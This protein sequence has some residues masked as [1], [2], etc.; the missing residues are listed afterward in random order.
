MTNATD[1]ALIEGHQKARKHERI[2]RIV[3]PIVALTVIGVFLFVIA[4]RVEQIDDKKL[5]AHLEKGSLRLTPTVEREL[6]S[7]GD[8]LAPVFEKAL[9]DQMKKK[10][11]VLKKRIAEAAEQVTVSST[12]RFESDLVASV[13]STE[14]QQR[15][16]LVEAIPE[17]KDDRAAQDRILASVRGSLLKWGMRQLNTTLHKH[18]L[19]LEDIRLTLKKSY[20]AGAAGGAGSD[21]DG[22]MLVFLELVNETLAADSGLLNGSE[23]PANAKKVEKKPAVP[24]QAKVEAPAAGSALAQTEK[25]QAEVQ[26]TPQP[27]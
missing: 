7:I 19:A 21:G 1:A 26:L 16:I 24:D 20:M 13:T 6:A 12:K 27:Q 8:A 9:D 23:D 2:G 25:L 14:A 15:A 11:P 5:A 18:T 22:T 4:K 3:F 10:Q 17:I